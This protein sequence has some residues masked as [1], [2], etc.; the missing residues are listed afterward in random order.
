MPLVRDC[1]AVA[2]LQERDDLEARLMK[3]AR[4]TVMLPAMRHALAQAL[5]VAV[6]KKAD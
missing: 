3:N 4:V 2:A 6:A 1:Q 5:E